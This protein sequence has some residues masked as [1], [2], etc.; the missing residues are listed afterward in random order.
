MNAMVGFRANAIGSLSPTPQ[1][2]LAAREKVWS[3]AKATV[4]GGVHQKAAVNQTQDGTSRTGVSNTLDQDT[5][6]RL[7]V[8]Q[9][10]MQDPL[11]PM[12]NENMIAQLAQFSSLE[13][14][15]KLNQRF[16][17]LSTALTGQ[18]FVAASNLLGLNVTG[19]TADG[20]SV[21]GTVER[22]FSNE[23]TVYV[24]VA[25]QTIPLNN[26]TEVQPA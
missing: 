2:R 7:L 25:D 3:M 4:L 9:M 6:L 22:V 10:Q 17:Q 5:F 8:L 18:H 16:E 24:Q 15:N 23:G 19:T 14:M 12:T 1:D 26:L 13:Q 20:I 11:E 21:T